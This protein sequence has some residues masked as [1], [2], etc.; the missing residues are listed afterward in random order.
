MPG[1]AERW[2]H[3]VFRCGDGWLSEAARGVLGRGASVKNKY[4]CLLL[5]HRATL[6]AMQIERSPLPNC[7]QYY[8]PIPTWIPTSQTLRHLR[9]SWSLLH[10]G[11]ELPGAGCP[12][13]CMVQF[14]FVD[15][16]MTSTHASS[17]HCISQ[18]TSLGLEFIIR[19]DC[20]IIKGKGSELSL[21]QRLWMVSR[22][23]HISFYCFCYK[24]VAGL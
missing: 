3:C 22:S 20:Q 19:P 12:P 4:T 17:S 24:W 11:E 8:S 16:D 21:K 14:P 13:P 9:L 1:E 15:D 7:L 23:P 18:V 5:M 2:F 10:G 6:A